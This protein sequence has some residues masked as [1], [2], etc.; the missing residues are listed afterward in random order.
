M[1]S[2]S[3][4]MG[5]MIGRTEAW[6]DVTSL[7]PPDGKFMECFRSGLKT[8]AER[9]RGREKPVVVRM[10]FGN[11]TG[12][13]VNCSAVIKALT[14]DL[15]EDAHVHLWVGAWRKGF[16]WN[17]SKM[18]AVDG[19]YLHTGGHNL[20]DAHYLTNNP[21]HDLSI[22]FEGKVARDGH[23]FADQQWAFVESKQRTCVGSVVDAMPD[24][25]PIAT[26]TRV[27]VSEYPEGVASVFPP[28]FNKDIVAGTSNESRSNEKDVPL[29]SIGR[30]G[31]IVRKSRPSDDAILAMINSSKKIIR[32]TLQDLGPV[33]IPSSKVALPGLKWPKAYL[34]A[35]G[36]A[37]YE[38]GVDVEIVLSN[39]NSIPGGLKGTEANYG[40]GWDCVDVAAEIIKRIQKQYTK[41]D[42]EK[43]RAMI[44]E[45][46]RICFIRHDKQSKYADGKSI[47]LHSKHFIVD[48][49]C[50]YIGSQNLYMCDLAEWGVV[51]D[52]ED[53]VKKIMEDYFVPMWNSSYTGE[54]VD[55]QKVMDG[56][57]VNRDG[58]SKIFGGGKNDAAAQ[59]LMPHGSFPE[60]YDFE[61]KD[62]DTAIEVSDGEAPV[63]GKN[64]SDEPATEDDSKDNDDAKDYDD[65]KDN[66]ETAPL[67]TP[68]AQD[69]ASSSLGNTDQENSN[70]DDSN[71]QSD[72]APEQGGDEKKDDDVSPDPSSQ[73]NQSQWD[74]QEYN[75]KFDNQEQV[76]KVRIDCN[77]C[78]MGEALAIN[79]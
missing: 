70:E 78:G 50:C 21:V 77:W 4:K 68:A 3:E 52:S 51:V 60:Y 29:I 72:A 8:L 65:S 49:T 26:K 12:M 37:I 73:A 38:R 48:D 66:S 5:E 74:Q 69:V 44:T 27:T 10:M 22:E 19:V 46:L 47:G 35:I 18:I 42:D 59:Q 14:K 16:S 23:R 57:K 32:M 63:V 41:V 2:G 43:L 58:E 79:K 54:D 1:T 34:A 24:Y 64:E 76:E 55:V 71:S 36:K 62:E 40:N 67:S 20:W 31:T 17:H 61:D 75:T 6:C 11:I 13:P 15:P 30:Q 33:C 45:N 56:L 9:S 25:L 53:E 39:P 28:H 7:G